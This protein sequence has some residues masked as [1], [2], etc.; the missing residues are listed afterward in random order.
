L[1]QKTKYLIIGQGIVGTWMSYFLTQQG[2][3]CIVI[4]DESTASASWV[5]SGVINPVTGRRIVQ[6]WMIDDILPFA[7]E[8]YKSF[9][10]FIG[11]SFFAN[12]SIILLHPS[13]Q[14]KESF[15]YRLDHDNVYL[16]EEADSNWQQYFHLEHSTGKIDQVYWIDLQE[17]ILQWRQHLMQHNIY[18]N[19]RFDSNDVTITDNGVQWKDIQAEYIVYCDGIRSQQNEL[20]TSLPFAPNKGEAIIAHIP[21]LPQDF[22]YKSSFSMVP[23][24]K[25]YFWIGSNYE[26]TYQDTLPSENFKEKV[27]QFLQQVL[28]VP[29]T[30]TDHIAGVRPANTER[31]PF[32]GVH[33][34]HP[35]IAICNGMGT[36]G[37]S[38]SP[39]FT[40][41]LIDYIE[42]GIPIHPEA[43]IDRFKLK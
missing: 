21:S 33:P 25:E 29:Y 10:Q 3:D 6:T 14:M 20:F 23:W 43:S 42:S 7:I 39:F 19:T 24:K 26:W 13:L 4:N 9:E 32:V 27:T 38:L 8:Q 12:K 11:A 17:M 35:R 37:C 40:K 30:I 36:K 5:A 15:Q 1:T 34:N 16:S 22:I 2:I 41:Q 18:I 28:K 31:R